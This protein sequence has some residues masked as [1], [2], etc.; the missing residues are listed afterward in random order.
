MKR[1]HWPTIEVYKCNPDSLSYREM[2]TPR[3]AAKSDHWH[4]I[5]LCK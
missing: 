3:K 1:Y 2:K 5:R 4:S